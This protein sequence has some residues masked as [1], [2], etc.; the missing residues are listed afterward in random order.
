MEGK[1]NKEDTKPIYDEKVKATIKA[2]LE[3]KSLEEIAKDMSYGNTKSLDIYMRRK[4]FRYNKVKENYEP[5]KT[6]REGET[7]EIPTSSRVAKAIQF[8]GKEG[9]D[10][11]ATAKR[12]G[13]KDHVDLANFMKINGYEYNMEIENYMK[14]KG[15]VNI[16]DDNGNTQE[17]PINV[18]DSPSYD[19]EIPAIQQDKKLTE[20]LL[21]GE[22]VAEYLNLLEMLR[23]NKDKLIDIL[24]PEIQNGKIPRF[25][26]GGT[27]ITK[28]VHMSNLLSEMVCEFSNE[29]NISQREIFEVALIEF[30]RRYGYESAVE[31]MFLR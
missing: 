18:E 20:S 2:L 8:L 22:H 25:V 9:A 28:S 29:K 12:L 1:I 31:T 7:L 11:K 30:F 13:F 4:N 15:E 10:P 6:V 17:I 21:H 23:K 5:L 26:V 14:K 27:F 24:L 19:S 16:A 3:G